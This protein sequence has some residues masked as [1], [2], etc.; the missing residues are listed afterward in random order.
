M[1]DI[2]VV[3]GPPPFLRHE[4]LPLISPFPSLLNVVT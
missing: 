3:L 2:I 4:G 1:E